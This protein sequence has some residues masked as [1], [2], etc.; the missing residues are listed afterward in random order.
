MFPRSLRKIFLGYKTGEFFFFSKI[1][2]YHEDPKIYKFS[3]VNAVRKGKPK[4]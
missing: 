2:F 4:P 1:D 3:K